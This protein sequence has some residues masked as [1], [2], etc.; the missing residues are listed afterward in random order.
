MSL[1]RQWN[2]KMHSNT[3]TTSSI[4]SKT[5]EEYL[6]HIYEVLRLLMKA[7]VTIKLKKCQFYDKRIDY[8]GHVIAR[9]KQQ[10]ARKPTDAVQALHHPTNTSEVRS[11]LGI[12]NVYRRFMPSF[13]HLATTL[14]KKLEK[15][16]PS[17]FEKNAVE[18]EA[19]DIL[20]RRLV[21]PPVLAQLQK[22]G[23]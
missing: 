2:G 23:P 4:F 20:K 3:S 19:V 7:G 21:T 1:L 9:G 15:G 16:D 11:L 8:L 6:T 17:W 14:N 12:C 5:L 13:R 10:V 22:D 18:H